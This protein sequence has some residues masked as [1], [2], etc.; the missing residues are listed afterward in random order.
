[1]RAG[2]ISDEEYLAKRKV[3][4]LIDKRAEQIRSNSGSSED[5]VEL[6]KIKDIEIFPA[7][8]SDVVVNS[9]TGESLESYITHFY[10]YDGAKRGSTPDGQFYTLASDPTV[11]R[12]K[13]AGS[14][15]SGPVLSK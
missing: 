4:E 11:N 6:W 2:K 13:I 9:K 5:D 3:M 7:S 15:H 8:P 12:W 10:S 14:S 1:M